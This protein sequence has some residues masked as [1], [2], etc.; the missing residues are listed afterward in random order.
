MRHCARCCCAAARRLHHAVFCKCQGLVHA[1]QARQVVVV[2]VAIQV[3]AMDS[4]SD[5]HCGA[6]TRIP[7]N[8]GVPVI[9]IRI[10]GGDEYKD[11]VTLYI[12]QV[13]Y[14]Q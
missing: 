8:R 9:S 11:W 2:G 6:P 10:S 13:Y 1:A 4:Q 3:V 14:K 7:G 5:G 12:Y